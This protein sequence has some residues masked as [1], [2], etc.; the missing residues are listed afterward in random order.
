MIKIFYCSKGGTNFCSYF[1]AWFLSRLSITDVYCGQ[2]TS[3]KDRQ[4]RLVSIQPI[5]LLF[6]CC[7][8]FTLI[9]KLSGCQVAKSI[10]AVL[11]SYSTFYKNYS[12]FISKSIQKFSTFGLEL[13]KITFNTWFFSDRSIFK[14]LKVRV[15][16]IRYENS[17]FLTIKD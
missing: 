10:F 4:R 16:T 15:S 13:G 12:T 6:I 17:Y 11:F 1:P 14:F 8:Y 7:V 3:L 5:R 9:M 2:D